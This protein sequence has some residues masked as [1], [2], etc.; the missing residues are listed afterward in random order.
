M[1]WMP[2]WTSVHGMIMC[3]S[4][5]GISP[6][7]RLKNWRTISKVSQRGFGTKAKMATVFAEDLV[8]EQGGVDIDQ[9]SEWMLAEKPVLRGDDL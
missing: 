4:A 9:V 1:E 5:C 2:G 7:F 8:N 3:T 6:C